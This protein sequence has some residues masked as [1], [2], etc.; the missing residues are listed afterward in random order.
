MKLKQIRLIVWTALL[1]ASLVSTVHAARKPNIVIILADDLGYGDLSSYGH[2]TIRTPHLDR[3]AAEGLRFTDFYAGN[4]YC[5]PSRAALLTGRLPIRS[6][7]SGQRGSHVLYPDKLGGLPAEEI[8]IAEALKAAGY[9]TCAIGKWHLGYTPQY[10]PT[11]NGFD[12][13]FGLIHSN[14]ANTPDNKTR[15]DDSLSQNPDFRN[16]DVPLYRGTNVIER[17][18]DQNTLT[19]RYTEEAIRFMGENKKKP[20][21]V[22][23]AHTFPHVPLFASEEFKGKSARGRYGDTVEELDASVGQILEWLKREKLDKDTL[24]IFTS[25]NGPWIQRQLNGGSPGLFRDGKGGTWEGGSRVPAIVRWPGKISPGLTHEM[26]NA[27]DLFVTSVKL[28]GGKMPADRPMDGVDMSPILFNQ[29]MGNRDVQFFYY[30]DFPCA[31]RKGKYKA[32]FISRDGYSKE[33]PVRHHP[34][35]LYD[36]GQD[37]SEKY[38]VASEHPLIVAEIAKIYREHT[39]TV[40]RGEPQF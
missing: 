12:H 35:L 14:D 32:H 8:T 4:A 27:M 24:V 37:P 22:Y 25:D 15:N 33:E 38:N 36:L 16:F 30:A 26:A 11:E 13:Y 3:M 29:G 1:A 6:G 34:P 7:M 28:A 10:A 39:N 40:T 2:P 9:A 31:V 23:L 5:T 20:F 21:F 17:P 19:K 18:A